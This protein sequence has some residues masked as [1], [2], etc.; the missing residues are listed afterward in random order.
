MMWSRVAERFR[1][2]D[3]PIAGLKSVDRL[4][5]GDE[6]GFL[7]RMYCADALRA[8]G[9]I[10]PIAQINHTLTLHCGAIRGMH[11]Q[12]PPYAEDKFISVVRG[13][14]FDVA[15]DLRRHSPTFLQWH[16]EILSAENS[17]SLL[18]PKGFAHGFQTL[19]DG[20]E[21]IYFHTASYRSEAE[22]GVSP[23][24]P[25]LSI[26]WP[27]EVTDIS[28]RDRSHPPLNQQFDGIT[29]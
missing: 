9:L 2:N 19:T 15:V 14:V 29:E 18:I 22:R 3:T 7:S 6:R 12:L 16:G 24:D 26:D 20:C 1:I 5:L 25:T 27:L 17:R 8:A 4:R 10:E 28:D 13:E 23:F 21:L 11:F